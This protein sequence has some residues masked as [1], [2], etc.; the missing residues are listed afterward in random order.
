MKTGAFGHIRMAQQAQ[1]CY[2]VSLRRKEI[3]LLVASKYGS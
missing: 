1:N 3:R 2:R